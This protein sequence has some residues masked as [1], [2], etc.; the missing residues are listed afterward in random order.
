MEITEK[1][2]TECSL[3]FLEKKFGLRQVAKLDEL[4]SWINLSKN[5][6]LSQAETLA[7]PLFQNILITNVSSWNEQDLSMHFIGPIFGL[8]N[9]TEPYQFNLFAER[10]ISAKVSTINE[11]MILLHGK[12]DEMIAS[13]FRDPESPFFCFQAVGEP[14]FK[15]EKDPNGDPIAQAL[16]AMLVGLAINEDKNPMYGC[17]VLGRDW[18]FMVLE[19]KQFAISRGFDAT[20]EGLYDL[21]KILKALKAIVVRLTS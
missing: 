20:T 6:V 1:A 12:P 3:G 18:Y 8:I 2:F 9:F 13:G 15:R 17:Y 21:F 10:K 16:A 11:E 4:E 5:Q 19:N 7:L 14:K